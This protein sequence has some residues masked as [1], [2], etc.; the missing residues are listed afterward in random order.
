MAACLL[1]ATPFSKFK[2]PFLENLFADLQTAG[3]SMSIFCRR[4]PQNP[5]PSQNRNHQNDPTSYPR[6]LDR[7]CRSVRVA[8]S[9]S[10]SVSAT[11]SENSIARPTL[12][13]ISI[14][15]LWAHATYACGTKDDSNSL[16]QFHGIGRPV[17]RARI[18]KH[19]A[20]A[21]SPKSW[22]TGMAVG[23]LRRACSRYWFF[24]MCGLFHSADLG[25]AHG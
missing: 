14:R 1:L 10:T 7:T 21:G 20:V 24:V 8:L 4:A 2:F 15:F 17:L 16:I 19:T 12:P 3:L 9:I 5:W 13:T 18:A 22:M 23:W 11:P 6:P 25:T